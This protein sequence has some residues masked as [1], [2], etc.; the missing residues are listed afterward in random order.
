M[1][2]YKPE[3]LKEMSVGEKKVTVITEIKQGTMGDLVTDGYWVNTKLKDDQIPEAKLKR[4]IEVIAAN[5]ATKVIA[6]PPGDEV[7]PKSNLGAWK[8]T[9]GDYPK[10]GQEIST[11]VDENG[12]NNIVLE[13]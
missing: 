12:F 6:L 2:E 11:K 1:D 7:N 3:E 10:V 5:G 9:Y 13:K 8:K 4:A